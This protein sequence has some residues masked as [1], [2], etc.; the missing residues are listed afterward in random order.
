[1]SVNKEIEAKLDQEHQKRLL[2]DIMHSNY[3]EVW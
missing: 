1:M 2:K 3:E